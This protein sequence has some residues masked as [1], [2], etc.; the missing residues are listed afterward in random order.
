M[1][2]MDLLISKY[3][4]GNATPAES[5]ELIQW[6]NSSPEN[7]MYF[8]QQKLLWLRLEKA[9]KVTADNRWE[10]LQSRIETRENEL[11][12]FN[13]QLDK[14]KERFM[15]IFRYAAILI[16]L[17]GI[18][19][20]IFYFSKPDASALLVTQ[21]IIE[22]PYGSKLSLTLPDRSRLWVNSGSKVIY[23]NKFGID[24]RDIQIIGE[25]YFDVAKNAKLPFV[26][27]AGNVKI[28]A[29]GTAFNV[30][31]YPEE[32]RVETTLIRGSVEIKKE[33]KKDAVL[34]RPSEKL[35][36]I[37][38]S[39]APLISSQTDQKALRKEDELTDEPLSNEV[40]ID[41]QVDTEKETAWKEG[42][43]IFDREPLETLT[44]QL[45]R[46]Y[47]VS[48]SFEDEK[49]KDYKFSGTFYDLSLEQ[50]MDAMRF[51]SPIDY[52]IIEK[53]VIIRKK[54]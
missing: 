40:A 41:K 27:H 48:F 26:V 24:N 31:A 29:L 52:E 5:D 6:L 4:S 44:I 37:N 16:L 20:G 9:D 39:E 47:D 49:L 7:R 32:K 36:I 23:N 1:D 51:S 15:R 22:V 42:K 45:M 28:K 19:G 13:E 10:E 38:S 54:Q 53:K 25:A 18:S 46:K 8:S 11:I 34:L 3:L 35:V 43:L 14:T 30:K 12:G 21:N 50:I 17:I 2:S 33:G